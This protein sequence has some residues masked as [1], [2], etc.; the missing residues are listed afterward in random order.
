[1]PIERSHKLTVLLNDDEAEM[2]RAIAERGGQTVSEYIRQ[3][4]RANYTDRRPPT[5][6][7]STQRK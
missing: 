3:H 6:P 7:K 4:I 5:K 2:L 1:M